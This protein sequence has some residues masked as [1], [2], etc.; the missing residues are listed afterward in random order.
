MTTAPDLIDGQCLDK[1]PHPAHEWH[2]PSFS[3]GGREVYLRCGGVAAPRLQIVEHAGIAITWWMIAGVDCD[4]S[5]EPRPFYCDRG[6]YIAKLH[7]RGR[8]RLEVDGQDG[9]PRYYFDRDRALLEIEA[10]L[11]KRGQLPD[12]PPA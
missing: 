10:W 12:M 11:D 1:S 7:P 9:W 3:A 5:V 2:Y 4:I 6:A 8:L